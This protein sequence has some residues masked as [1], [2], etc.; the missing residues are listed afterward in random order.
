[1]DPA[2]IGELA[3]P[4][5]IRERSPRLNART[6]PLHL[7]SALRPRSGNARGPADPGRRGP[8]SR[9]NL[10]D[11]TIH[12]DLFASGRDEVRARTHHRTTRSTAGSSFVRTR[13]SP[14][15]AMK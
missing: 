7:R 9:A 2:A 1:M 6:Y 8:V 14:S 10:L 12:A 11:P 13:P 3:Q 5:A 15:P 4:P